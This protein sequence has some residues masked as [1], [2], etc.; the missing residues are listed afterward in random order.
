MHSERDARHMAGMSVS[1]GQLTIMNVPPA[2]LAEVWPLVVPGIREVIALNSASYIPEQVYHT[3]AIGAAWLYLGA[4]DGRMIGF[5][6]VEPKCENQLSGERWANVWILHG[7]HQSHHMQ[8]VCDFLDRL[9]E[10]V[11]VAKLRFGSS[12][13]GWEKLSSGYWKIKEVIYE[14][15]V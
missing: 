6:I 5:M 9:A 4:V 10:H 7:I 8:Q 12:R 1:D 15:V 13:K 14:R 11:G 3:I 2:R